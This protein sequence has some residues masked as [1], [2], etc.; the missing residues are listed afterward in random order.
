VELTGAHDGHFEFRLC[1]RNSRNEP[2][3]DACFNKNLLQLADGS[4]YKVK[5]TRRK[6]LYSTKVKLPK[7]VKCSRCVI[8]WHYRTG[9]NWGDCGNGSYD[10]GCGPQETFRGCSDVSIN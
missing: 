9:N 8:Q 10:V 5:A 4:G 2:E 6:G 1:A 7:G 3:S